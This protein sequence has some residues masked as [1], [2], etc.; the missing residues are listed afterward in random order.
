VKIAAWADRHARA[1]L[2]LLLA[3]VAGGIFGTL[4]LP[5]SLFPHVEFARIR[6][7]IEAG[8]RPAEQMSI[9]ITRPVEEALRAVPGVRTVHSTTSRGSA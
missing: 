9:Q 3:L 8:E 2:F 4:S 7:N 6:V 5:V 1:I